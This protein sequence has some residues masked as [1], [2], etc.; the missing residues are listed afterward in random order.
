MRGEAALDEAADVAAVEYAT[1]I[2][3][4]AVDVDAEVETEVRI[5]APLCRVRCC[6]RE[7]TANGGGDSR[8]RIGVG[9]ILFSSRAGDGGDS[10][11]VARTGAEYSS[12]YVLGIMNRKAG[13]ISSSS[14]SLRADETR[15]TGAADSGSGNARLRTEIDD[16]GPRDTERGGWS[17][18]RGTFAATS[19][20]VRRCLDNGNIGI[21]GLL[22]ATFG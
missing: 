8:C 22:N 19:L 14:T 5:E 6:G 17:S 18:A 10:T 16:S 15:R 13:M 7:V 20:D 12:S 4:V 11:T 1:V 21:V 2:G 3:D 9:T